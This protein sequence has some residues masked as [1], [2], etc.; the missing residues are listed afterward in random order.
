M[1]RRTLTLLSTVAQAEL[2]LSFLRRETRE[3]RLGLIPLNN[4]VAFASGEQR[5]CAEQECEVSGSL[6]CFL[7][8]PQ[9]AKHFPPLQAFTLTA[10][11]RLRCSNLELIF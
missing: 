10:E 9:S 11:V 4:L 3:A 2:V 1:L 7:C 8:S 5:M 6:C